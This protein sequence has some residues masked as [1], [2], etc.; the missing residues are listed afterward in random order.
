MGVTRDGWGHALDAM[1]DRLRNL[2]RER[3]HAGGW[4]Y[5]SLL[6]TWVC[7]LD[8]DPIWAA[9]VGALRN[10]A[11]AGRYHHLD[12]IRGAGFASS[13]SWDMWMVVEGVAVEH[14]QSLASDYST[15]RDGGGEWRAF[16]ERLRGVVADSIKR[17]VSI[18]CLVGFHGVLGDDW[19]SIGAQLLPDHALPVRALPDCE[20]S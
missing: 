5:Q 6:V 19:K 15:V 17:W 8:N 16:E 9:A 13:S 4:E 11:D 20:A 18:I 3:V 1:D 2:I 12:Q 7:T 10:Y 14:D